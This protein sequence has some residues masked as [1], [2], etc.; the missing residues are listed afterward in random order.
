MEVVLDFEAFVGRP[1]QT[2]WA[3]SFLAKHANTPIPNKRASQST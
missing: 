3:R 1:L 2:R